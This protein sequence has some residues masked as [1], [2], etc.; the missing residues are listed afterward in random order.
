MTYST[1]QKFE[2]QLIAD[3][4]NLFYSH[5]Y[6]YSFFSTENVELQKMEQ[7]F[8]AIKLSLNTKKSKSLNFSKDNIQDKYTTKFSSNSFYI[9][10]YSLNCTKF[11]TFLHRPKL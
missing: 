7:L 5:Q 8:K 1:H 3:E 9:K 11:S 10:K 2:S 6:T 4:K